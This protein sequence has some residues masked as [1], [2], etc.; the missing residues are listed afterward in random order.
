MNN[1]YI[2]AFYRTYQDNTY[3]KSEERSAQTTQIKLDNDTWNAQNKPITN[4][5]AG[6]NNTDVAVV[7]QTLIQDGQTNKFK[8]GHKSFEFMQPLSTKNINWSA[9][10]RRITYIADAKESDDAVS[11]GQIIKYDKDK[12]HWDAKSHK[13]SNVAAATDGHDAVNYNQVMHT[14][15]KC[16]YANNKIISKV[17]QGHSFGDVLTYE[18]SMVLNSNNKAYNGNGNKITNIK[19]GEKPGEVMTYEHVLTFKNGILN[20]NDRPLE[21]TFR[22]GY[23]NVLTYNIQLG[24]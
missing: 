23:G 8:L 1:H 16:W 4:V 7:G 11:Y 13:I 19:S 24:T 18:Q 6:T 9:K 21:M 5:T 14:D 17:K 20:Y 12:K 15:D 22:D 3:E 2:D 10:R